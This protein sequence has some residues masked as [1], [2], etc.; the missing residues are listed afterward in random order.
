MYRWAWVSLALLLQHPYGADSVC[1]QTTARSMAMSPLAVA[2]W[3]LSLVSGS[4]PRSTTSLVRPSISAHM[5]HLFI[6]MLAEFDGFFTHNHPAVIQEHLGE[7]E[8][9]ARVS[10]QRIRAR[11]FVNRQLVPAH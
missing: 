6:L 10:H 2:S 7:I 8:E 4:A 9:F 1:L 5:L 3:S 11:P